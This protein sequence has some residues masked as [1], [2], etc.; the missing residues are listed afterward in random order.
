METIW[1]LIDRVLVLDIL[2]SDE[3]ADSRMKPYCLLGKIKKS[4]SDVDD[5]IVR[6]GYVRVD[7]E[8]RILRS[9]TISRKYS[10]LHYEKPIINFPKTPSQVFLQN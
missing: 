8:E 5:D 7:L 9:P 3:W 6:F 10:K 4:L 1:P 2:K